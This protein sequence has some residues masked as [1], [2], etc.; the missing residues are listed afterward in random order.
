MMDRTFDPR[1]PE[2]TLEIIINFGFDTFANQINEISA[3][4]T[5]ELAIENVRWNQEYEHDCDN[6]EC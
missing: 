2:F 5:K 4:A 6:A 1:T 3:A